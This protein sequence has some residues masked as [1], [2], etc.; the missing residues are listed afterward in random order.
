MGH[1]RDVERIRQRLPA[2]GRSPEELLRLARLVAFFA[3]EPLPGGAEGLFPRFAGL[4]ETLTDALSRPGSEPDELEERFLELYAHLHGHEAPYR[5]EERALVDRRGGYW[6]HAGGLTPILKAPDW[7]REDSVAVDFGAANGLQGL[8]MQWLRPHRLFVQVEISAEALETGRRLQ[9]WL[10]VSPER[11]AWRVE[12]VCDAARGAADYDFV[13]LYRP[14]RPEGEGRVF[15]ERL[16][17]GLAARDAPTTV[18]SIADCL[19]PFLDSHFEVT[20]DD[21]QLSCFHAAGRLP[22]SEEE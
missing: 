5:P 13:Y 8:L 21:G 2:E 4:Q 6:A 14:V 18:F 12:D 10:G 11:L 19:G 1:S 16:A 20:Y 7:L 3:S 22:A 15:Y 9:Q 17:A